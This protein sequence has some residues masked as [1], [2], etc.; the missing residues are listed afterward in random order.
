M[1]LSKYLLLV[2][3][4][5]KL[6]TRGF[7]L[8]LSI[9]ASATSRCYAASATGL[10]YKYKVKHLSVTHKCDDFSCSIMHAQVDR[11][12][13]QSCVGW[14]MRFLVYASLYTA[15]YAYID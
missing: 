15:A 12:L 8:N 7:S 3:N 14:P 2:Y 5:A 10:A 6:E 4:L 9:T 1:H 13:Q 11:C